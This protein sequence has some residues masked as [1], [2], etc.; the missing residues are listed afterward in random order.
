MTTREFYTA[1]QN[2]NVDDALKEFAATAIQKMDE[3][4]KKRSSK[5]T[6]AQIENAPIKAAINE[7]LGSEPLTATQVA[8]TLNIS[9]Q[10]ASNLLWRMV[11]ETSRSRKR[12]SV[13]RCVCHGIAHGLHRCDGG[14]RPHQ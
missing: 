5:P 7:M 1:I 9:V 4:N 3:K 10:K 6:K 14:H 2:A 12:Q 13:R 11:E 8:E